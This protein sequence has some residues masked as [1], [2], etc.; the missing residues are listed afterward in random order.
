MNSRGSAW[1]PFG[2]RL[3]LVRRSTVRR[4]L[5]GATAGLTLVFVTGAGAPSVAVMADAEL[6]RLLRAMAFL[7]LA[8]L[9]PLM[10]ATWWRFG[11]PVSARRAAAYLA[12]NVVGLTGWG[13]MARLS[14]GAWAPSLFYGGL[15]G[16]VILFGTERHPPTN[17]LE[18]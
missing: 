2:E 9:L 7:K 14:H 6:A 4:G 15:I 16:V 3:R 5:L 12:A 8:F 10:A 1:S 17:P 13:C 18:R 11:Q